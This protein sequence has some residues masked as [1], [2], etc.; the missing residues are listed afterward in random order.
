MT[1]C[2]LLRVIRGFEEKPWISVAK[3]EKEKLEKETQEGLI[4]ESNTITDTDNF[5]QTLQ[6]YSNPSQRINYMI[7]Q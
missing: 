1:G 6:M 4:G 3:A 7:L 2:K 5:A